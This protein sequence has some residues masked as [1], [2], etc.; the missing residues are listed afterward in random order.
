VGRRTDFRIAARKCFFIRKRFEDR[1]LIL[2]LGFLAAVSFIWLVVKTGRKPS[3][4]TYPCQRAAVANIHVFLVALLPSLEG[5]R[6]A[7]LDSLHFLNNRAVK[8]TA[9]VCCL[10]LALGVPLNLDYFPTTREQ[11]A[12]AAELVQLDLKPQNALASLISSDLF[13]VQNVSGA[14]GDCDAAFSTFISL[15]QGYGLYFYKTST[16]P[17]GLIAR[18]DV[19]LIKVNAVGSERAGTNTD[20]V[21]SLI[22]MIVN[23]PEGFSGEVVIVDNGQDTGGLDLAENN[24]F[25]HSQSFQ[26]VA[27]MF[28]SFKVSAFS[29]YPMRSNVVSEYSQGDLND[30]YV[31][32]LTENPVTHLRASYPKFKT[33]YGTHLSF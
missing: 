25:D 14:N 18:E 27:N 1:R 20:L 19:V 13:F 9:L 23:H 31:V 33:K 15:M 12:D 2:E 30:G 10:L 21:K 8:A 16:Q 7:G 6:R 32:N 29:C 22:K 28:G 3:R 5:F 11:F 17:N 26:D 4:I 24:A